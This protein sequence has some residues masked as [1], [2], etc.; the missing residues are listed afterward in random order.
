[1][2]PKGFRQVRDWP[3][4]VNNRGEIYSSIRERLLTV[5]PNAQGYPRIRIGPYTR[6][7]KTFTVHILVAE[8]WIGPR[9]CGMTINHKDGIKTNNHVSNL[10]Y[11]S[12]GDNARHA[13]RLGL[14]HAPQGESS[15][16]SKLTGYQVKRIRRE[17]VRGTTK[18]IDLA[19]KYS[20]SQSLIS[21]I[22]LRQAWR[23]LL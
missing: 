4:A 10:E 23:H 11:V 12:Q 18:Q 22:I 8:C 14:R 17:Y 1:M 7:F 2:F 6:A 15:C 5:I 21:M 13:Y 19:D 9:P 16:R 3:Y 20:V